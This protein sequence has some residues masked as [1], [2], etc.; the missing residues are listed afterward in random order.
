MLLESDSQF[1][2][3]CDRDGMYHSFCMTCLQNIGTAFTDEAISGAETFVFGD[4]VT[5]S[6]A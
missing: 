1:S 4:R 6:V 2:R 5:R 3:A